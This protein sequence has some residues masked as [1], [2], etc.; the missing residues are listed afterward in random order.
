MSN[1]T[2]L[3]FSDDHLQEL[4]V[5]YVLGHLSESERQEFEQLLQQQPQLLTQVDQCQ[6]VMATLAYKTRLTPSPQLRERI[7]AIAD[8]ATTPAPSTTMLTGAAVSRAK[9]FSRSRSLW[10]RLGVV[11]AAVTL[12]WL[13]VDNFLLRRQLHGLELAFQEVQERETLKFELKGTA[14]ASNS[15][16][17]VLLDIETGKAFIGVQNLPP[18]KPG[19]IYRLWAITQDKKILCGE[20]NTLPSGQLISFFPIP[21]K[22]YSSSIKVMR[23]SREAHTTPHRPETRVMV[24]SSGI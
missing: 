11:L 15:T 2:S 13:A 12:G 23:I 8:P 3:D 7:L 19:E 14:V 6:E 18:L 20:F 10:P 24:L 5:G 16:A 22:E 1:P 4:L 17:S 9:P 21:M